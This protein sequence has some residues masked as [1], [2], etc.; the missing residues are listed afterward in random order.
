[1]TLALVS[2]RASAALRLLLLHD[3]MV[4]HLVQG[5]G[6]LPGWTGTFPQLARS[7]DAIDPA[8]TSPVFLLSDGAARIADRR[9]RI[10]WHLASPSER[11][12]STYMQWKRYLR[13]AGIIANTGLG[14]ATSR[15]Y[16]PDRDLWTLA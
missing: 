15:A 12:T 4:R 9:G 1:M 3:P 13:H 11:R 14:G 2:P 10:Q 8:R 5:L 6:S 16:R 7:S